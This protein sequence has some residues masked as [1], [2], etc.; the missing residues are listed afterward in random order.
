VPPRLRRR[1]LRS[2][3]GDPRAH[4]GRSRHPALGRDRG[5][6]GRRPPHADLFRLPGHTR[7]RAGG[8]G[9]AARGGL[10]AAHRA[11][12]FARLDDGLDHRGRPRQTRCLWHCAAA[13]CVELGPRPVRRGAGRL[14]EMRFGRNGAHFRVRLDALQGALP[15]HGLPR[16]VRLLQVPVAMSTGFHELKVASI[17]RQTPDAVA[18]SLELPPELRPRFAF[19]PG[20]YL[21]LAAKIDGRE[22]RRSYSIC[23]APDDPVLTVGVKRLADGRFSG[24][25]HERLRVGDTLR[26]M[27]PQGRFTALAGPRHDY[28]LI[29][30][31]SGITP[32][33]SIARTVLAHEPDSTITLVYGNRSTD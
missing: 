23:S 3:P 10:R 20:Q 16:A 32:M 33:L 29:A 5:R 26:V 27:P 24:F 9:R 11:R 21:T 14:P 30:A 8:R 7:H 22:M 6:R 15:L 1:L 25:I 28:V 13:A 31:G 18:L 2:R 19:R 12:A 17:A 4:R